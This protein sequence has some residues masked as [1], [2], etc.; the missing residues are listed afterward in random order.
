MPEQISRPINQQWRVVRV[1]GVLTILFF[2]SCF[3]PGLAGIDGMDGGFAII[4]ICGFLVICGMVVISVYSHRARQLD[5]MINND[6]NLARWEIEKSLWIQYISLDFAEDK[7]ISKGTFILIAIISLV[8]GIALSLLFQDILMLFICLGII[9]MLIIPAFTFPWFRKRKKLKNPALVIISENSV[10]VGGT[11][12][13]WDMLGARLN[14]VQMDT[15]G[16][17]LI[18]RFNMSYP[19]RTGIENYEIRVPVPPGKVEEALR[20]QAHFG[21]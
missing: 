21:Y 20:I 5:K 4:T 16:Q 10:Y 1:W 6:Q 14:K 9:V 8:I 11:Y 17:P 13:N 3:L 2:A 7:S 18:L 19:A 15:S 12:F